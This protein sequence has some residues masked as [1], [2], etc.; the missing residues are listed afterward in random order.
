MIGQA[1]LNSLI[2]IAYEAS[3]DPENWAVFI[4]ECRDFF[5]AD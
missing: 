4:R 1:G 3:L 5:G 2:D